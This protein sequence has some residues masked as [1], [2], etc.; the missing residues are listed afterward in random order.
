NRLRKEELAG[1]AGALGADAGGA[2]GALRARLWRAGAA[3]EAGGEQELGCPWQPIPAVL[4]GRLVA[5]G[6]VRGLAPPAAALPRPVPPNGIAPPP[7]ADEPDTLEELLARATALCGVRLGARGRDKGEYGARIAALLGLCERGVSEP[8][9]RGEVEVKTV[10]VVRDP[11]GLWRVAEDPAVSMADVAPASKLGRVLWVARVADDAASPI[12]SWYYQEW[13]AVVASLA[14]RC[15]HT[16]PKGPA[17]ATSRGWYLHKRF[18]A[19]CGFLATLNG[20]C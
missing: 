4:G 7:L 6:P 16:R 1:L 8:D 15:L 12:L 18:F 14:R 2:V 17:G 9:W 3:L 20:P 19:G 11:G 5:I 13:D 10:P